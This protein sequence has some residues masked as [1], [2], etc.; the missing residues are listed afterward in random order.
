MLAFEA[1]QSGIQQVS[2]NLVAG[3]IVWFM[4]TACPGVSRAASRRGRAFDGGRVY[5]P[6]LVEVLAPFR[7]AE[8]VCQEARDAGYSRIC[9][10]TPPTMTATIK[11]YTAL[12]FKPIEPYVFNPVPG[13]MF[14]ALAL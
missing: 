11:P 2:A 9:L 7:L 4:T 14:L 13:A 1:C 6:L 5:A 3:A 8:R 10:D 12:G